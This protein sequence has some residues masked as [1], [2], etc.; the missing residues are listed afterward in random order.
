M[1]IPDAGK[2][3]EVEYVTTDPKTMSFTSAI[4]AGSL[5]VVFM[6]GKRSGAA[7][8]V[9][10]VTDSKGNT[11]QVIQNPSTTQFA[12]IAWTR[13]D[14]PLGTSDTITVNLAGAPSYA[15]LS[16]HVFEGASKTPTDTEVATGFD[17]VISRPLSVTGSDW[18]TLA[19][20][21]LPNDFGV[22]ATPLNSS[23]SQDDNA[24]ASSSPWIE[25][26][27]RNGTTGST[28]TIGASIAVDV[29]YTIC[30]VSF[31]FQALPAGRGSATIL[32][33]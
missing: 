14:Q 23:V 32:F 10:N 1:A 27:S 19:V 25:C 29:T 3:F 20:I 2:Q 4:K 26:F 30:A 16:C 33:F 31:P 18:L 13:T 24:R 5:V 12:A 21:M 28:H 7:Q 9:T 22:T 15:W 17:D 8:S 11:Y 6:G